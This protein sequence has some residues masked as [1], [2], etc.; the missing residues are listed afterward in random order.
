MHALAVQYFAGV[1]KNMPS[2]FSMSRRDLALWQC[3][4]TPHAY[5]Y[6]LD[7]PADG[8]G[9][10]IGPRQFSAVLGYRLGISLFVV[11]SFCLCC[12][13]GMDVYGDHAL[14]CACEVDYKF[15]HDLVRDIPLRIFVTMR[16]Y[17]LELKLIWGFFLMMAVMLS[18]LLS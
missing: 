17:L 12:N 2:L 11:N 14:H 4:K 8:L 7:I 15:R 3:N 5:N 6:L 13:S 9:K 18:R 10:K 16:M 1:T